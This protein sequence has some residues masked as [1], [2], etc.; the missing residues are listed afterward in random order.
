MFIALTIGGL[1]LFIFL[2]AIIQRT[3]TSQRITGDDA[4][5]RQNTEDVVTTLTDGR[6]DGIIPAEPPL[7]IPA[8]EITDT[9]PVPPANEEFDP[10]SPLITDEQPKDP[11][12][13]LEQRADLRLLE[14]H[15]DKEFQDLQLKDRMAQ[16][17]RNSVTNLGLQGLG[18]TLDDGT[19]RGNVPGANN[20]VSQL[21]ALTQRLQGLQQP[22]TGNAP[23]ISPFPGLAALGAGQ[24]DPNG[25]AN[26]QA[27]LNNADDTEDYLAR[28]LQEPLSPY[29][30]KQGTIIPGLMVTGINSDL[31]GRIVG[32][33]SQ[34][35]YDTATGQHLLIPSGTR[36][37]GRYDSS[38]TFGQSRVLVAW[39]RLI[40]PD[41]TAINIEAMAGGDQSGRGGFRD[42]VNNHYFRIYGN[43]LLL[44][45]IGGGI[46][47]IRDRNGSNDELAD[48]IREN[49]GETF[50]QV[51]Q[52]TI[53]KNLDIQPT[54]EIRPGYRF[55]ILVE[56][57]MIL[58]PYRPVN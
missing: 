15:Y 53:Q 50:N 46:D 42:R 29:E 49:F 43:A 47:A 37:F 58:R 33:V 21:T 25:Q 55:V 12:T 44:S 39:T 23:G 51:V 24:Q 57:D 3:S 19:R 40:Y 27:F 54:L 11:F 16:E 45:V 36:V 26:K 28:R 20:P 56:K 41:G 35:V 2:L 8:P 18:N 1:I 32:Q 5:E 10:D 48:A 14:Y 31:P 52:Q 38:V 22:G 17:A 30:V 6:P 9:R 7:V 4:G 34:N 13:E